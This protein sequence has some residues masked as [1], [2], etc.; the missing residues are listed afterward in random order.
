MEKEKMVRQ[1]CRN[2]EHYE[3][4]QD[5]IGSKTPPTEGLCKRF[6]PVAVGTDEG[7]VC[8]RPVV[9]WF[10]YCGEYELHLNA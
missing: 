2:C 7:V 9:E 5:E 10:D 4:L 8:V 6:P 1:I 3:Q